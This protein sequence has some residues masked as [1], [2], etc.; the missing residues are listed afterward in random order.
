MKTIGKSDE[1]LGITLDAVFADAKL[2]PRLKDLGLT[3]EK[4]LK[5]KEALPHLVEAAEALIADPEKNWQKALGHL[6]EAVGAGGKELARDAINGAAKKVFKEGSLPRTILG[7]PAFV[8]SLL[9][10]PDYLK[11][12]KSGD[13]GAGLRAL[14]QNKE[15]RD[16]VLKALG[17]SAAMKKAME[18]FGL[19]PEDLRTMG[20]AAVNVFEAGEALAQNPPDFKTALSRIT[21][22]HKALKDQGVKD[23]DI[24]RLSAKLVN[25]LPLPQKIKDVVA[26]FATVP[27][28]VEDL[29]SALKAL[30]EGKGDEFVKHI[31]RAGRALPADT[32]VSFLNALGKLPKPIGPLFK[33]E[34]LNRAIVQTGAFDKFMTAAEKIAT[35][36]VEEAVK[37]LGSACKNLM[38]AGD[39]IGFDI[40]WWLGGG[41]VEM[42]FND[43][44]FQAIGNAFEGLIS[45]MPDYVQKKLRDQ[46][47]KAVVSSTVRNIPI[48][49]NIASLISAVGSASDLINSNWNDPLDVLINAGQLGVDVAGIIPGGNNIGSAAGLV[50]KT[51]KIL[52][53]VRTVINSVDQFRSALSGDFMAGLG[54]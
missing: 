21:G 7:D 46:L 1:L 8:G 10:N 36:E 17:N 13:V 54:E 45:A 14:M 5:A 6:V 26:K 39:P 30:K 15:A 43:G 18:R 22:I 41:R 27:G 52:R 29:A 49:G 42:P 38:N 44:A 24:A 28:A 32:K 35:G 40:P 25:G 9:D 51:A 31:A 53:G 33:N 37:E 23:E 20:L 12:F 47:A 19:K 50:L 3:K 2:G 4:L 48:V 11:H 34:S 16:V